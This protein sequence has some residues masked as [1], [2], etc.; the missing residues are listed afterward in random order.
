MVRAA[1]CGPPPCPPA[2]S[3]HRVVMVFSRILAWFGGGRPKSPAAPRA[4]APP[5]RR[6]RGKV[7][8]WR[9]YEPLHHSISGTMS[10]FYKVRD[11]ETGDIVG[12][13]ILDPKKVGPIEGRYKGLGKPSEGEIGA[14]ITGRH[15][16][17]TLDWG[18]A[19]D[20]TAFIV[21]EFL[22][23]QLLH[24]ILSTRRLLPPAQRL[25]LVRQA[26]TALATVHKAGF[27]HRD[28][29]PRNFILCPDGRLVLFDF[30]L[31]VPDKPVFLQPGNRIGT[32]NYMAPEVVRRRQADRRI[33]VFSFGVTAYEICTLELPWPRGTTGRAAL[34]H[35]TTPQ[36]IVTHWP[37]IP[38]PLGKA[39]MSCIEPDGTRR[40]AT[41]DEFLT[42]IAAVDLGSAGATPA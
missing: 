24:G 11:K 36:D 40:P 29:C 6:R 30:G 12:L 33:D 25:E 5:D 42:R 34:Q 31:T 27:V 8:V 18:T 38:P 37:D 32:P 28:I 35:E 16:V 23:G 4:T 1:A 41:L 39:I 22:D 10:S 7:D 21:E 14:H 20:G 15:V 9:R 13:K 3:G 2:P 19:K 26:A 17:R